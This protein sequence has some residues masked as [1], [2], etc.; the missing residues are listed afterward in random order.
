MEFDVEEIGFLLGESA[1]SSIVKKLVDKSKDKDTAKK[2]EED[3]TIP[4]K[5]EEEQEQKDLLEEE[6]EQKKE[7]VLQQKNL[8]DF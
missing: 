1:D 5:H 3:K 7:P 6:P 2:E 8:T 4:E